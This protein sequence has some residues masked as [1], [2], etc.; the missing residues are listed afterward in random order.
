VTS[1][2]HSDTPSSPNTTRHP[3]LREEPTK[4]C[5]GPPE[6]KGQTPASPRTPRPRP[7]APR[8]STRSG[9]PPAVEGL[10]ST[11]R[12]TPSGGRT[13]SSCGSTE[14]FRPFRFAK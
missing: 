1:R 11:V 5:L 4:R 13:P 2:S 8:R 6:E 14:R 7:G 10:H 3:G 9:P 12:L